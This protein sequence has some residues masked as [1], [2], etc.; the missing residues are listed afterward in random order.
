MMWELIVLYDEVVFCL[1][2]IGDVVLMD[3]DSPPSAK[4]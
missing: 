2:Y 1:T 4:L 3:R